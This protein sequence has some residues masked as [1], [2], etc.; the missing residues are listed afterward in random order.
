MVKGLSSLFG[1]N[2]ADSA[3]YRGL[4]LLSDCAAKFDGEVA[5]Y[6][7]LVRERNHGGADF[8]RAAVDHPEDTRL[9]IARIRLCF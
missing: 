7:G 2:V 4:R 1:Q 8:A 5:P 6:V 3:V 9:L